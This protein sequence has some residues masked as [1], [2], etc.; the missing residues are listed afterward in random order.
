MPSSCTAKIRGRVRIL[1]EFL[2][3]RCRE[4]AEHVRVVCV[5]GE[6][7]DRAGAGVEIVAAV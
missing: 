5:E 3:E 2:T 4:N 7:V 6:R 1:E